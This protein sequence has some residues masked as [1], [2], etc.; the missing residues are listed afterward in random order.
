MKSDRAD[1]NKQKR[2][3]MIDFLTDSGAEIVS[4]KLNIGTKTRIY[5]VRPLRL[6]EFEINTN[7]ESLI[8][9]YSSRRQY[10]MR[11]VMVALIFAVLLFV[12]GVLMAV[13]D[14]YV[15]ES[16][17]IEFAGAI[18]EAL[19][20]LLIFILIPKYRCKINELTAQREIH[21]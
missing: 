12:L 20:A 10:H 5:T 18:F 4:E 6:G 21:E 16:A 19:L 11:W 7:I 13:L 14:G 3:Q 1:A 8:S 15:S 9:D 17:W 2:D